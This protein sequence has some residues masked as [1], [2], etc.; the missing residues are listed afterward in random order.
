MFLASFHYV[1]HQL[2]AQR[3]PLLDF[4]LFCSV[5]LNLLFCREYRSI[6]FYFRLAEIK[7]L[8]SQYSFCICQESGVLFRT[9]ILTFKDATSNLNFSNKHNTIS[10][11]NS[12]LTFKD[13][14]SNLN[15]S[16][17]HITPKMC[18]IFIIFMFNAC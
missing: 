15:F 14:P 2:F 10:Q 7:T 16:N 1:P 18:H 12:S 8:Y 5:L 11:I 3:N 9:S 6:Q 13:A 17:K 4:S